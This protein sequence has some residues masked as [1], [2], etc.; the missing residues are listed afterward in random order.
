MKMCILA[1]IK[2]LLAQRFLIIECCYRCGIRQPLVWWCS[3]DE[4]W[5]EVTNFKEGNGI[6]CPNCFD[7][8]AKEK[9]IA[10]RWLA[11]EEY[12]FTAR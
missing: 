5:R 6:Y 9:G 11:V 4:L 1:R 3:N 7:R 2:T 8:M 12:K 10:I